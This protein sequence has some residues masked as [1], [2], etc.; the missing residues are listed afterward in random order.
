MLQRPPSRVPLPK[1]LTNVSL[2]ALSVIAT[3]GAAEVGLRTLFPPSHSYFVM[4]PGRD[5]T[6]TAAPDLL[7]GVTGIGHFRVN[8]FGVRG[9]EFGDDAEYR[10]LAVGGSTTQCAVLD[11]TEVWTHVLETALGRTADG[12]PVWVGNV[13]RDGATSRDLVMHVKYLLGQYP[14]IDAVV[15]LVGVNDMISALHQGWHY[16][17]PQPVTEPRAEQAQR[18][19]AFAVVPG[20]IQDPVGYPT[21]HLPWYKTTAL[22]QLARRARAARRLHRTFVLQDRAGPAL[23]HARDERYHTG[24]WIDSLPPLEAPLVEYRRNLNAMADIAAAAGARIVFVTQPSLWRSGLPDREE[25]LLWFG[26]VGTD[27]PSATAFFTTGALS[28]AMARYNETLLI[29]CRERRLECVDAAGALPH[30]TTALY[31]DV[32]FNEHGSQLLGSALAGYFSGRPP[33]RRP[34]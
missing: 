14:R 1:S 11:D 23:Q 33:F 10:I 34:T 12:R 19:R 16:R 32:H 4:R 25:R 7:P 20:R 31:D 28:R 6:V 2:A 24:A 30:D 15:S 5:W 13:G 17:P 29:V 26:W 18:Q 3:L 21:L 22:W 8:R 9:R 27:R